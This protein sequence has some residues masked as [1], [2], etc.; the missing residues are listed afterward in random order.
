MTM[1]DKL[2]RSRLIDKVCT[3]IASLLVAIFIAGVLTLFTCLVLV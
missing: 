1:T 3:C 2:M